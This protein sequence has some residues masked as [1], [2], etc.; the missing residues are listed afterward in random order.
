MFDTSK[1]AV[2]VETEGVKHRVWLRRNLRPGTFKPMVFILHNPSTADEI[3]NDPTARRGIGFATSCE[4]S[5]LIFVNAATACATDAKDLDPFK[6]NCL[7]ADWAIAEAVR[8]ARASDG[9]VVAAWGAPKG[10]RATQLGMEARFD[11]IRQRHAGDLY[12]LRVTKR[13]WPEHPLY[14][15][16]D[17]RPQPWA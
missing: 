16:A 13:G 5:D 11:E 8:L 2:F 10:K 7:E 9:Y 17:L 12:A 1:T 6:L 4:C 14:L 15:P 3:K